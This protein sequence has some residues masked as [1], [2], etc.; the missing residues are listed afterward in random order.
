M[1]GGIGAGDTLGQTLMDSV[2]VGDCRQHKLSG[3]DL[4]L[5]VTRNI[6]HTH[7]HLSHTL[8]T[9]H[10]VLPSSSL[11]SCNPAEGHK[12]NPIST[13]LSGNVSHFLSIIALQTERERGRGGKRTTGTFRQSP[14]IQNN[15]GHLQGAATSSATT[16]PVVTCRGMVS[17]VSSMRVAPV[18]PNWG[19]SGTRSVWPSMSRCSIWPHWWLSCIWSRRVTSIG[20]VAS[21]RS[22]WW[23]LSSWI[24]LLGGEILLYAFT[25]HV[26]NCSCNQAHETVL[27][28]VLQI[29][30]RYLYYFLSSQCV[31]RTFNLFSF[32][33]SRT[34]FFKIKRYFSTVLWNT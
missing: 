1:N 31:C 2:P 30:L 32:L 25:P 29:N 11:Q 17:V 33:K 34:L 3:S 5:A 10:S 15:Q 24:T 9:P 22:P 12:L 23:L 7:P 21:V 20:V 27:F 28:L 19:P 8:F 16:Q 18:R 6:S 26:C 14:R 4:G 13:W